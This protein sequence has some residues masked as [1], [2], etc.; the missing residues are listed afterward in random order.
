MNYSIGSM[1]MKS[2]PHHVFPDDN[3]IIC[4]H[5]GHKQ[6]FNVVGLQECQNPG[7]NKRFFIREK[8]KMTV[9]A[10][11]SDLPE[12]ARLIAQEHPLG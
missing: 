9:S 10:Q 11:F 8:Y 3:E 6:F 2:S 12:M 7:C 1:N 4:P 5:C